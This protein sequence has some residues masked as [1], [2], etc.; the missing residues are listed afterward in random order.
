MLGTQ[1]TFLVRNPNKNMS[2][3]ATLRYAQV[4]D[5][6]KLNQKWE[7]MEEEIGDITSNQLEEVPITPKHDWVN[8][9]DGTYQT[10]M[11]VCSLGKNPEPA[12]AQ[13]SAL[14]V[15]TACDFITYSYNRQALEIKIQDLL[16]EYNEYLPR[17]KYSKPTKEWIKD[18]V[19]DSE[20]LRS[21]ARIQ[22]SLRRGEEIVFDPARIRQVLYRPF[23]KLWLYEDDRILSSV[24]SVSRLFPRN[25]TT[26]GVSFTSGSGRGTEDT[27]IAHDVQPDL[28]SVRGGGGKGLSRGDDSDQQRQQYDIP[29]TGYSV[30][31][32]PSNDQGLPADAGNPAPEVTGG[33]GRDSRHL[34]IEQGGLR[35]PRNRGHLRP[36]RSGDPTGQSGP[37]PEAMML[38]GP[39]NMARFGVLA[40]S[41]LADLHTMAAGQ[42]TRVI[43]RRR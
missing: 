4:P 26:E 14:G 11:P 13:A 36:L 27:A 33:G 32:G 19:K 1:I 38:T 35:D 9:S 24:R 39:S 29:G 17:V 34:S 25:E 41:R 16:D 15:A 30:A 5:Y 37:S 23:T 22:D 28:N 2:E 40:G 20:Y 31:H 21:I 43:P 8:L 3:P 6:L 12:V 42:Q 7:W 18:L 10:M